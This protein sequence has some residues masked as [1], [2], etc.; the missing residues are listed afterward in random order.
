MNALVIVKNLKKYF[1]VKGGVFRTT[2]G[3]V[4]AVDGISLYIRRG[5]CLGL[6]GESG[7]G[8]TT[9]G[10]TVIRLLKPTEGSIYFDVPPDVIERIE[11]LEK[12]NP[13]DPELERL[14]KEYDLA[15][16]KG[17]RLKR[18]R[19]RM[20]IVYQDPSTSLNPRMLVKD[21]VG[22]PLKVFKLVDGNEV[23]E[24][25]LA[26]LERVGLSEQHLYRYPHEFSGG[27]RQRI[28][29][30]RAIILQPEFIVLDEPTS[31]VDV[32]V[33]AQLLKLFKSLQEDMKL[34]YLFISHELNI[35][36][37]ISD[38]VGVMYLGRLVELAPTRALFKKQLHPYTEALFSAIPIPDPDAKKKRILLRGNVPSPVNPPSGCRFH[39][40]CPYAMDICREKEPNLKE[41]EKGR[42]VACH[43]YG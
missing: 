23:T 37:S 11:E 29:I 21:I 9:F 4:K 31:A 6:V 25:V 42:K 32:S 38:R 12:R 39:P 30:A 20:Q 33:K 41:V 8:K 1:P 2:I 7:C 5:E 28:A 18:L 3:Y 35:V 19:R 16:Y 27:Q 34:T 10:K 22:E 24:R 43:L 26:T 14:R 15:T 36:E 13:K 40:R 17:S